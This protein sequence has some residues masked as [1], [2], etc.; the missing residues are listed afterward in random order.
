MFIAPCDVVLSD[1]NVVQPDLLFISQEHRHLLSGGEN[2]QATGNADEEAAEDAPMTTTP[3]E[4]KLARSQR[5]ADEDG[6]EMCFRQ[7]KPCVY[8][9]ETDEN[10]IITEWPNGVVEH[11]NIRTKTVTRTWPNGSTE[12]FPTGSPEDREYPH[13]T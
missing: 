5:R 11:M 9:S 12:T 6:R 3:T 10:T 1:T 4:P 13:L 2:V 7:G 8:Q